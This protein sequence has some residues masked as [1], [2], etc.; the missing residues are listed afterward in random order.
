MILRGY[1]YKPFG[2]PAAAPRV[3][4]AT[5]TRDASI[6]VSTILRIECPLAHQVAAL[7]KLQESETLYSRSRRFRVIR[8]RR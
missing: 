4:L 8:L 1:N 2:A 3:G 5:T 7:R 6:S